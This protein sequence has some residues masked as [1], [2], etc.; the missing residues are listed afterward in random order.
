[1][2]WIA[3]DGSSTALSARR[4]NLVTL[5]V[6]AALA[7]GLAAAFGLMV[8]TPLRGIFD[9]SPVNGWEALA[10]GVALGLWLLAGLLIYFLYS[11]KHSRL[12]NAA[13]NS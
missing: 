1:M 12:Q 5:G 8:L 11:V 4:V 7:L 2:C 3:E 13:S 10:I 9:L 6:F